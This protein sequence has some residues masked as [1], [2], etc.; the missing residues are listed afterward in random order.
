MEINSKPT[1]DFITQF[2]YLFPNNHITQTRKNFYEDVKEVYESMF[3]SLVGCL[4]TGELVFYKE[5][6][7]TTLFKDESDDV[8]KL[9]DG[10]EIMKCS[11]YEIKKYPHG[12]EMLAV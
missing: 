3:G 10:S 12:T 1:I 11:H 7:F 2:P 6:R 8:I 4:P 9:N 5:G